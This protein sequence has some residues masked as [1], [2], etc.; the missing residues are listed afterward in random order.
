[1]TGRARRFVATAKGYEP[2]GVVVRTAAATARKSGAVGSTTTS[3][4]AIR[5]GPDEV[6]KT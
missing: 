1:M 5:S 4:E 6:V 2:S 3:H